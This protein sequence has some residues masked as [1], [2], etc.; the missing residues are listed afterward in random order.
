MPRRVSVGGCASLAFTLFAYTPV[1]LMHTEVSVRYG[2]QERPRL[3]LAYVDGDLPDYASR[4]RRTLQDL[5]RSN[6][7]EGPLYSI[8]PTPRFTHTLVPSFALGSDS[9][10]DLSA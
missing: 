10:R 5:Q 7:H 9:K 3:P 4:H 1:V 8:R 6:P 2:T